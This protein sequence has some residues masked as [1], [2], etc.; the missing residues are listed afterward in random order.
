[1]NLV[2][3]FFLN[4]N[5]PSLAEIANRQLWSS[6]IYKLLKVLAASLLHSNQSLE[7]FENK[8][9]TTTKSSLNPDADNNQPI[10]TSLSSIVLLDCLLVTMRLLFNSLCTKKVGAASAEFVSVGSSNSGSADSS[11]NETKHLVEVSDGNDIS[12]GETPSKK[13]KRTHSVGKLSLGLQVSNSNRY[14]FD[15]NIGLFKS[16][17]ESS[18]SNSSPDF[19]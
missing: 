4:S 7:F 9:R 3:D 17:E 19:F 14:N 2:I 15:I 13:S 11:F 12:C 6:K 18:D 5:Y 16:F 10:A 1:M 8:F